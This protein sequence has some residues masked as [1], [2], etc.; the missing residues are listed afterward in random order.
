MAGVAEYSPRKML[1]YAEQLRRAHISL[2]P[3]N[4][5]PSAV[6]DP[7]VTIP[8]LLLNATATEIYF[9]FLIYNS[10]KEPP[11]P[12]SNLLDLFKMLPAH[13]AH[14]I[15]HLW[16]H[17]KPSQAR[18]RQLQSE[19]SGQPIPSFDQALAEAADAI[20]KFRY[21]YEYHVRDLAYWASDIGECARTFIFDEFYRGEFEDVRLPLP[22]NAVS[23]NDANSVRKF[24]ISAADI[25]ASTSD[26][27]EGVENRGDSPSHPNNMGVI[28]PDLDRPIHV[29]A[30][31][32]ENGRHFLMAA[33]AAHESEWARFSRKWKFYLERFGIDP[34]FKMSR[35]GHKDRDPGWVK[36]QALYRLIEKHVRVVF[37]CVV[38][39]EA[40]RRLTRESK[41]NKGLAKPYDLASHRVHFWAAKKFPGRSR[42]FLDSTTHDKVI[43]RVWRNIEL[44]NIPTGGSLPEMVKDEDYMPIQGA[45]LFA[46]WAFKWWERNGLKGIQEFPWDSYAPI[47]LEIEIIDEESIRDMLVNLA[48]D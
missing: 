37:L 13:I 26:G 2:E 24:E 29:F 16:E 21:P 38:D 14:G 35:D 6:A 25:S 46:W 19:G 22:A 47:R 18:L 34:A 28:I 1:L 48:G 31:E 23:K 44:N 32:S 42:L 39:I 36:T 8:M 3:N 45:D 9:K 11:P 40:L 7:H 4:Y 30:D 15:R 41:A 5:D 17:P 20:R 43:R 12:T 10:K 33:L 27:R